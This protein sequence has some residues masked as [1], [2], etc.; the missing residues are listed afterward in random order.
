MSKSQLA[1]TRYIIVKGDDQPVVR[2]VPVAK[3]PVGALRAQTAEPVATQTTTPARHDR[4]RV[5]RIMRSAVR[6]TR[7]SSE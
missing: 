7:R 3:R 1:S 6:R 5:S 4:P 2:T